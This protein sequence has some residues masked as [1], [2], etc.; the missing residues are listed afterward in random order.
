MSVRKAGVLVAGAG[1]AGLAVARALPGRD[2]RVF[3]EAPEPRTSGGSVTLWP[4]GVAILRELGVDPA[5]SGR[6]LT[7]MSSYGARGRKLFRIDLRRAER[8]YGHPSVHVARSELIEQLTDGLRVEYG[9]AVSAVEP[10]RARLRL[11]DGRAVDGDVLVG[12]DGRRSVV[13]DAV[14]GD[15]PARL[16]GWVTWQGYVEGADGEEVT[17]IVG[18]EGLCGLAPAGRDRL[19]WW[20]DVRSAPGEPLWAGDPDPVGAIRERFAGY[21]GP[22]PG[23]LAALEEAEFFPHYRHAVPGVWGRGPTTLAGD[24][25]H[26]MPPAMAQGANQALEDAWALAR[27]LEDLRS[28]ERARARVVRR[29]A[30][31]AATELT[32]R[33]RLPAPDALVTGCYVRWLRYASSYLA[34]ARQR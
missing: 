6:R 15:D 28:Y 2:V 29:P 20:F 18:P 12:A 26:S 16:S 14:W 4:A 7:A 5:A 34:A 22:V 32:G 3:E 33:L 27:S 31:L 30:R 13:R 11:A 23:V 25:A 8:A 10:D 1:I 21:A 24:A 9:A 19:L 17:L